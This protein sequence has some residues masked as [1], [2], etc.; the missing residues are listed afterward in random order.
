MNDCLSQIIEEKYRIQIVE[1]QHKIR[2]TTAIRRIFVR[3]TIAS[4][5]N[6][7]GPIEDTP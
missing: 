7:M 1:C 3:E 2:K 5:G 6:H 4:L